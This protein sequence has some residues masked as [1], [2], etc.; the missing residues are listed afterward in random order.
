MKE[1]AQFLLDYLVD[2]GKGHLISGP[3]LSPEN[4]YRTSDGAIAKLCM[5]PTMDLEIVHALFSRVITAGQLLDVDA[6]FRS[7]LASARD[8]LP[9]LKIGKHGQLQEWL[10]DYDEPDPGHG[11]FHSSSRCIRE[12][13]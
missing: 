12:I 9:P 3:S 10:E 8:R 6:E 13:R 5:G 7:R 11:T 1:A 2:D 4:R